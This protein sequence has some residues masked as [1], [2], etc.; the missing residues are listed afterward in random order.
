MIADQVAGVN[1]L[2]SIVA[3]LGTRKLHLMELTFVSK[4]KSGRRLFIGNQLVLRLTSKLY[5][6][7]PLLCRQLDVTNSSADGRP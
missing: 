3:C 2:D 5:L 1:N 6:Q 7:S 4:A